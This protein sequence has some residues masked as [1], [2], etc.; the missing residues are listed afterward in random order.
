MYGTCR[1]GHFEFR[2]M[3]SMKEAGASAV[4]VQQS[5]LTQLLDKSFRKSVANLR[6]LTNLVL[7]SYHTTRG[8]AAAFLK[9]VV[10]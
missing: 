5:R 2:D 4:L 6:C 9:L 1:R 8:L 3:L 10:C 7:R